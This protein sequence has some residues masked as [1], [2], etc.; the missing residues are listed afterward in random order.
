V[1]SSEGEVLIYDGDNPAAT[2]WVLTRR[3]SIAKPL[4][5]NR[6]CNSVISANQDVYV[7][8]SEGTISINQLLAGDPV[9]KTSPV[10]SEI[11]IAWTYQTSLQELGNTWNHAL[12]FDNQKGWL[13]SNLSADSD[14]SINTYVKSFKTGSTTKYPV[15]ASAWT[16]YETNLYFISLGVVYKIAE[17]NSTEGSIWALSSHW[18]DLGKPYVQKTITA[19]RVRL[20]STIYNP[21]SPNNNTFDI[22]CSIDADFVTAGNQFTFSRTSA[23]R[24]ATPDPWVPCHAT[25]TR[26]RINLNGST[27]GGATIGAIDIRY[28]IGRV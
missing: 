15:D 16:S 22:T 24:S 2:N 8:T 23:Q 3:L 9:G 1:I 10:A 13:F 12:H 27:L 21:I 11:G 18:S 4:Q 25:G 14:Y 5:R 17:S 28:T 26:F 7:L 20:D 19:I 6:Y